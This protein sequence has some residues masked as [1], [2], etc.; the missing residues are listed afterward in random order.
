VCGAGVIGVVVV[1]SVVVIVGV[2]G[3]RKKLEGF[4]QAF[5]DLGINLEGFF[6]LLGK[7]L[8]GII[9]YPVVAT[10]TSASC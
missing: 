2:F 4:S 6:L 5:V 1:E 7:S 3:L 10:R 9:H 8:F